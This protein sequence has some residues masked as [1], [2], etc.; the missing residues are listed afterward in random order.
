MTRVWSAGA[1]HE[2]VIRIYI[3][4]QTP[5]G[6]FQTSE[7][8]PSSEI[9]VRKGLQSPRWTIWKAENTKIA[10]V[11]SAKSMQRWSGASKKKGYEGCM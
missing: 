3:I 2:F 4:A 9:V 8:L 7:E 11:P 1:R 5:S 6:S 10:E